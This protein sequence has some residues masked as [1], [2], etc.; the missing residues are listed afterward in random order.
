MAIVHPL[1]AKEVKGK[2]QGDRQ[3]Q[4]VKPRPCYELETLDGRVGTMAHKFTIIIGGTTYTKTQATQLFRQMVRTSLLGQPIPQP[5]HAALAEILPRHPRY[6]EKVGN[7]VAAFR[8][9]GGGRFGTRMFE[10]LRTDDT[11]MTFSY[12]ACLSASEEGPAKDAIWAMRCEA[13]EQTR[14]FFD[15]AFKRTAVFC[16]ITGERLTPKNSHVDHMR[17][18]TFQRLARD[19]LASRNIQ[20]GAV[21]T[22]R[23]PSSTSTMADRDLAQAWQ[24]YHQT[25]A[26]LRIASKRANLQERKPKVDFA[27]AL[28]LF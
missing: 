24:E 26:K 18:L 27:P 21:A 11:T 13:M 20:P 14:S 5:D 15:D 17:P 10:I 6:A 19:F 22:V 2:S 23:G 3:G 4:A 7:G 8:V 28:T 12:L 16:E 1:E 9:V 25:H